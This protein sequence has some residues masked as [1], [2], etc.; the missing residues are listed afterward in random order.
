MPLD[1]DVLENRAQQLT[2]IGSDIL[3]DLAA[4]KQE[5]GTLGAAQPQA[6]APSAPTQIPVQDGN[7]PAPVKP[8]EAALQAPVAADQ[9]PAAGDAPQ[10]TPPTIA[11]VSPAPEPLA[12]KPQF[13]PGPVPGQTPVP[14]PP[15][16]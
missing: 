3:R 6:D 5:L 15:R 4:A 10:F 11:P 8:E 13:A 1:L 7:D 12:P 14:Q 9:E 2:Q 16:V